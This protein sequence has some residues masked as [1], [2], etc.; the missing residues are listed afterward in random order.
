MK[1]KEPKRDFKMMLRNLVFSSVSMFAGERSLIS[2]IYI[3]LAVVQL[4]TCDYEQK[5]Y[6]S[7][8]FVFLYCIRTSCN[9]NKNV[10]C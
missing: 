10:R 2:P 6:Y 3:I 9:V 5:F 7:T 8:Y 1:Y 4:D